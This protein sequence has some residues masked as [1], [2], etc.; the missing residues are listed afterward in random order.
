VHGEEALPLQPQVH[1]LLSWIH[2]PHPTLLFNAYL[3]RYLGFKAISAS[4]A[5]SMELPA[6]FS[7]PLIGKGKKW[8]RCLFIAESPLGDSKRFFYDPK[9]KGQLRENLFDLLGIKKN[10]DGLLEFR[11]KG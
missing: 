9:S 10:H 3:Y 5:Y 11:E 8:T 6:N 4:R 2:A 1:D 7:L